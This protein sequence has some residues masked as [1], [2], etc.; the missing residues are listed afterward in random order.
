MMDFSS[1]DFLDFL[2]RDNDGYDI[3][4]ELQ[5]QALGNDVAESRYTVYILVCFDT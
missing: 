2:E 1:E 4:Q 3:G 5:D